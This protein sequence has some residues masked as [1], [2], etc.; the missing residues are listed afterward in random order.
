MFRKTSVTRAPI[1][2]LRT[3]R[4]ARAALRQHWPEYLMEAAELGMFMISA[5]AFVTLVEY[6][7]S[8]LRQLIA[9]A[10]LRR[11]L[12]G[13]AMGLTAIAIVYSPWGKQSGAHFNPAVTLTFWRLGKVATWDA[14]FYILAHFAGALLGVLVAAAL[15][16]GR[17]AH[18][19]VNYVVTLPGSAG[20][21][22]AFVAEFLM[23][24][25]LMSVVLTVSNTPQL[26]RYTGLCCGALVA[27]YISIE[28]PVSGMS[29]NPAR[30]FGS[31]LVAHIWNGL[32]IYFTAPPLAMLTAA[33]VYVYLRGEVGC[34]KLDHQNEK[35]CIFC[36]K[37]AGR[38]D[39]SEPH[40]FSCSAA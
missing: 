30:T 26:T 1:E 39:I 10:T 36:G 16:G 6:P 32:W 34:A 35:R 17:I 4:G 5:A 21:S 20:P 18:P 29:I 11:A 27:A 22:T 2:G 15:L 7:G 38:A 37:P 8:A 14:V 12:T 25:G 19:T 33:Q 3:D 28:A 23:A 24:F 9:D 13:I 31:A 40:R